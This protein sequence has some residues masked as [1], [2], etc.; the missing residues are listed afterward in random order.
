MESTAPGRTG[1]ASSISRTKAFYGAVVACVDDPAVRAIVPRITR[2]V[3]SY[4]LAERGDGAEPQVRVERVALEAFGS[5]A[6]VAQKHADGQ[7]APL[8]ELRL[9][10]PGRHNVLNALAAVAVAI[11]RASRFRRSPRRSRVPRRERRFQLRG[12]ERG[13]MVVDDT[14]ITRPRSPR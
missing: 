1:E 6:A 4:G 3:I 12:E 14:D 8:G 7:H 13:V 2:R 5:R 11:E 10:V 9:R